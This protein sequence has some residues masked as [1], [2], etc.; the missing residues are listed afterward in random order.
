MIVHR[1][2]QLRNIDALVPFEYSLAK[3]QFNNS[4]KR[5]KTSS[6]YFCKITLTMINSCLVSCGEWS[7]D[8]GV[9]VLH[10]INAELTANDASQNKQAKHRV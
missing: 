3:N 5:I 1:N 9:S 4:F 8:I 2:G 7:M 10:A 6:M